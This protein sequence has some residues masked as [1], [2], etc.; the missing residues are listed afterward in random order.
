M[1]SCETRRSSF[2]TARNG[3]SGSGLQVRLLLGEGLV[4]DPLGG[5]VHARIGDRVEPMPELGVQVVE[6]AERAGEEEVLADVAER[7]LD[8]ALGLGPVGPAGLGLEA[9]VRGRGRRGA[10]VDDAAL[11]VLA[12]DRGLHAVVEDLA[13]H[14]ADRLEGGD[15]AAQDGLQV[16][17][18]DEARPDQPARPSTRENSQTMRVTPGS[19]VKLTS[20]WAKSTWACSPG[21]VSKRTSNG[22][23]RRRPE[24]R[25]GSP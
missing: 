24:C 17:V 21:G 3:A 7:P 9:V 8:L 20:K 15:V 23:R 22:W 4:D 11:G 12:D 1:P 16:L 10:V 19:S 5:G 25:A 13:R 14:A 6:V 18:D 2:S